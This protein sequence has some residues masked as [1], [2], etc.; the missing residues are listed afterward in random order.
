MGFRAQHDLEETAREVI[1]EVTLVLASTLTTEL[2]HLTIG[3][4][5]W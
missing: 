2:S 3:H 4:L 5:G 1:T